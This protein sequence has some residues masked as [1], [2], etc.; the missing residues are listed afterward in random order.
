MLGPPA[1]QRSLSFVYSE[2]IPAEE[3]ETETRKARA[4][5]ENFMTVAEKI[6]GEFKEPIYIVEKKRPRVSICR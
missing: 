6:W 1:R 4:D 3:K 5:R 2:I